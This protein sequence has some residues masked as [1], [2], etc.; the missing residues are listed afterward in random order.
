MMKQSISRKELCGY[1]TRLRESMTDGRNFPPSHVRFFDSRS[2]YYFFSKCPCGSETVEEVL[3]QMEDCI[4][5]AITE[6]SLQLFLSAYQ[7]ENSPYLTHSF[8]ESSKADFL[9]LVRHA[10]KDDGQWQAVITLCEGLRQK[11]TS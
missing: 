11:N 3:M 4:P 1:L 9:L 10:A 8:L 2:F 6:E 5:L 7:K